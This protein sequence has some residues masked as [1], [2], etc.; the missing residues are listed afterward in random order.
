[1]TKG[2]KYIDEDNMKAVLRDRLASLEVQKYQQQTTI[3]SM[4]DSKAYKK[5]PDALALQIEQCEKTIEQ[6]DEMIVNTEGYLAKIGG[7]EE[8]EASHNNRTARRASKKASANG[9]TPVE[10]VAK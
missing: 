4:K 9:K 2:F 5:D 10:P 7:D 8:S 6:I 3:R 1:M